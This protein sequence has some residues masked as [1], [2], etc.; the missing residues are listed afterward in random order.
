MAAQPP[1][2]P[3][4]PVR[5][6]NPNGRSPLVL[7]CEHAS[8]HIPERFDHLG[9]PPEARETHIAWDPGALAVAERMSKKLDARLVAGTLSRLIYDCNRPPDAPD[10]MPDRSEA[11]D[12]PGNVDLSDAEKDARI[13][14]IYEPFHAV[15]AQMLAKSPKAVCVTV[16]SF[17]PTYHGQPR[18]VEIGVLH[19]EDARLADAMLAIAAQHTLMRV[20]RNAPYGPQDGVTHTLQRHALPAGHPNV[21]IEVRSDLIATSAEQQAMGTM[22]AH[23]I[24]AACGDIDT[25][26]VI[27]CTA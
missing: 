21:M 22:L 5:T 25:I 12:I 18:S 20:E 17:T 14:G 9:L 26:G 23:W 13:K 15:V 2:S 24:S 16:H 4:A 10:A 6:V 11:Y 19:D 1:A 7:V 8:A 3:T 27:K